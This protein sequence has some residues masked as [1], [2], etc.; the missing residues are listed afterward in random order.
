VLASYRQVELRNGAK[1][2]TAA[3]RAG[4]RTFATEHLLQVPGCSDDCA[5]VSMAAAG[6]MVAVATKH[7]E[8]YYVSTAGLDMTL[9][10]DGLV[11]ILP[12]DL[13]V[14][15]SHDASTSAC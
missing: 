7:N 5:P 1:L 14:W 15:L 3:C 6:D 4:L 11:G 2:T 10:V 9:K 8:V 13:E 12:T